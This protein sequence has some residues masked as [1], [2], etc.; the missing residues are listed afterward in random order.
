MAN[1]SFP[2]REEELLKQWRDREI[3]RKTLDKPAPKGDFVFYEGPPTANGKPG[4]HH[5]IARAYKDVIPRF[6]TMQGYRVLRKGGWDTHGLPVELQVEKALGISGKRQIESLKGEGNVFESV[7][8]FNELCKKSVWEYKAEWEKLTERMAYWVDMER[9][10]VTYDNDYIESLWWVLHKMWSRILRPESKEK[11]RLLFEGHKVVPFCV[12]CGTALSSHELAQGYKKV[13]DTAVY[14]KFPLREEK[15]TYIL[16]W[17]TTPWTL[18]GNVALAVKHELEYVLIKIAGKEEKYW[19]AENRLSVIKEEYEILDKL[20]G[21]QLR[22]KKYIPLFDIEPLKKAA[23]GTPAYTVVEAPFVT[24]DDGTGVVHTA[25]M[26]GEDDYNLGESIGLPKVHTVTEEGKFLA[27]VGIAKDKFVKSKE[28]EEEILAK[29]KEKNLLYFQEEYEH[30][31]P[32][33]WRCDTPLLYYARN[34]WFVWMSALRNELI[35]ANVGNKEKNLAGVKWNPEHIRDGR[36]GEWLNGVKDWAISRDRYWGTPLPIWKCKKISCSHKQFMGGEKLGLEKSLEHIRT[37]AKDFHRPFIDQV[38]FPCEDCGAQAKRVPEVVDVWF[39]SGAMPFAQWHYPFENAEMVGQPGKGGAQFPAD[40]IAEAIDQTR[41]W[42]YTLLAVSVALG[43]DAPYKNVV[44]ISHILDKQGK[45]MSKSRGNVV[46]PWEI[47]ATHG[48]DALRWHL[49]AMSQPGEPKYFDKADVGAV[50]KKNFLILWNVVN[51]Y[52]MYADPSGSEK[53]SERTPTINFSQTGQRP[54]DLN[55]NSIDGV[56]VEVFSR[57][58]MDQWIVARLHALRNDVT[59]NMD[60]Y[61]VTEAV[62]ALGEF[63]NE[64]STRY[65]RSSR[66][67]FKSADAGVRDEAVAT[68]RLVLGELAK[69]MAPFTPFVAETVYE[70]VGGVE[71]SVHL[72]AWPEAQTVDKKVLQNM[73]NVWKLIAQGLAVRDEKKIKLRQPL[74]RATVGVKLDDALAK[75][76]A[77]ELNVEVVEYGK[78]PEGV[79]VELDTQITPELEKKGVLR[80]LVRTVNNMRK[81]QGLTI[82]DMV[83]VHYSTDDALLKEVISYNIDYLKKATISKSWTESP[84]SGDKSIINGREIIFLLYYK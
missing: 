58:V 69:L 2:K 16:S 76:V 41:G 52:Q 53:S 48:M 24:A 82:K 77:D 74:A 79:Y 7:K 26:Y 71:R 12:R 57:H 35:E 23:V 22:G 55:R 62:R 83:T 44:C 50:V 54:S 84:A 15:N 42:F 36:F 70:A 33:C 5:V 17:T 43:Y 45:K 1:I 29:L 28:V 75:I 51:F 59:E 47:A 30:D 9:P 73:E 66:D 21:N 32:N 67:R 64:L 11:K 38:E 81:K 39:D 25:V 27:K 13:K 56:S 72:E 8:Y 3:F 78:L 6:K 18:P 31:Y 20:K 10:Y 61:R 65:V 40:Y 80:E 60:S 37:T 46:D 14:I 68:L 34:S 19:L 63:I 4:L 49:F